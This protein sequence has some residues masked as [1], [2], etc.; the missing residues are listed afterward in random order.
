[1]PRTATETGNTWPA[2]GK[3]KPPRIGRNRQKSAIMG[4]MQQ[5]KGATGERE[6]SGILRE[7]G[8]DTQRGGS[9]TYGSIPDIVG[10]P[11]I[12]IECKRAERLDLLAAIR[13]AEADAARFNDG[14]PCVF[15][16]KNRSP[17]IVSMTLENF[18]RLYEKG[19][20]TK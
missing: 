18:M 1:M 11:D 16:R 20:D 15:H 8:Y 2:T 5:R 9:L 14:M 17:W 7:Y 4:K 19:K 3:R 13:Q 12:H 6:L 10:L